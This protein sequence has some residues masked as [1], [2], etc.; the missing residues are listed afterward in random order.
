MKIL[1]SVFT[2]H[3]E[4]NGVAHAAYV[5]AKFLISLGHEVCVYT[6]GNC[7]EGKCLNGI[8][9]MYF[10]IKGSGS[11]IK[12][13]VGEIEKYINM[14][15]TN[16]FDVIFSYCWQT[17]NTGLIPRL[18]NF[19]GKIVLVSHGI[20]VN[21]WFDFKS[22]VHSISWTLY[23]KNEIKN[24]YSKVNDVI[25]LSDIKDFDRFYDAL[26]MPQHVSKWVIRNPVVPYINEN[27]EYSKQIEILCIGA[28]S[29]LKNEKFLIKAL[30]DR[31]FEN[32][33]LRMYG[34]LHS[35]YYA[36]L[37]KLIKKNEIDF[38]KRNINIVTYS[39]DTDEQIEKAYVKADVFVSTSETECQ[40]MVI[41]DAMRFSVPFLSKKV[42]SVPEFSG[43]FVYTSLQELQENL[44]Y[45]IR[46]RDVRVEMGKAGFEYIR[47]NHSYTNY[48]KI[49]SAL[50]DRLAVDND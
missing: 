28:F 37:I 35:S 19:R 36:S 42:G 43:G 23:K 20:S 6:A 33:S 47:K 46:N 38:N 34:N 44:L 24:I 41:L 32:I 29:R 39:G 26:V 12:P 30:L 50:L 16:C 25:Y 21:T 18:N 13:I 4:R 49:N 3:P 11:I 40:P 14:V 10:N 7:M 22:L 1:I 27:K 31:R 15:E 5:H 45:L 9:I 8:N 48:A 17:W 2:F